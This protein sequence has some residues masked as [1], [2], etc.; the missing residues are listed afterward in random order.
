LST[1]RNGLAPAPL[2]NRRAATHGAY[3]TRFTP[4]ELAEI[5]EI[6]NE[7]RSLTP[8]DSPAIEPVIALAA[9]QI[10]RRDR[11]FRDLTEHGITRGRAD[12]GKVAPA[13]L[14]LDALERQLAESLKMLCLAPKAAADLGHKLAQTRSSDRFNVDRLSR[15]ERA[16]LD[17]LLSKARET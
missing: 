7:L 9:G 17:H 6:E 8:V 10:W 1:K 5:A 15:D 14:A 2:G 11:L 12:R 3:V 16:T 4:A 13:A